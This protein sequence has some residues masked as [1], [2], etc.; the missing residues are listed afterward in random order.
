MKAQGMFTDRHVEAKA[1]ARMKVSAEHRPIA[2]PQRSSEEAT[3]TPS[4]NVPSH[5]RTQLC[6]KCER[7][8]ESRTV[9]FTPQA[10]TTTF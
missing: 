9:A 3:A 7:Q 4:N 10:L 6:V 8:K 5:F 1:H 2:R